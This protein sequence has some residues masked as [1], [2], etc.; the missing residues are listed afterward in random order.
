[1]RHPLRRLFLHH[2]ACALALLAATAAP[3]LAG[4]DQDPK[5]GDKHHQ[6]ELAKWDTNHD[7]KL[8]DGEKAAMWADRATKLKEKN[9]ELFAKIDTNGDGTISPEEWKAGQAL[10]DEMRQKHDHPD[11]HHQE[12]LAKYDTNH[13]GKLD[14]GERA[15]K[16]KEKNPDLFAKID[17]NGDGKISPE[18]WKA[19]QALMDEQRQKHE[20]RDKP[21]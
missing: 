15:A 3:A 16:L 1:M 17:T 10:L 8:D 19:A 7:G 20:K 2:G 12:E 9:P 18:E 6:E 21:K 5:A 14:D 4:D 13:D 11:Q